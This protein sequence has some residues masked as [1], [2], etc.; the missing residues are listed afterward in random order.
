[1]ST[2]RHGAV[3]EQCKELICREAQLQNERLG[4][5]DVGFSTVRLSTQQ[6]PEMNMTRV[7]MSNL[8]SFPLVY[9]QSLH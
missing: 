1:M 7:C 9:G 5:V 4:L 6:T 2:S 3:R 8:E